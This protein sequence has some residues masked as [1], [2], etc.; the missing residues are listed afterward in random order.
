MSPICDYFRVSDITGPTAS[1]L[2]YADSQAM[3]CGGGA[4]VV[5][6][7]ALLPESFRGCLSSIPSKSWP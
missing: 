6:F 4:G 1:L 5:G 3:G 2:G 7:G